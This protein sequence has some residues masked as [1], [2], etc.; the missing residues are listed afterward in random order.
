MRRIELADF[1]R[2]RDEYDQIVSACADLD[3]FCSSAAWVLPAH[4]S[5]MPKR[6]PLIFEASGRWITLARGSDPRGFSYLEP[7]EASWGL[8]SPLVAADA[9]DLSWV[10]ANE[11]WDL[12]LLAGLIDGSVVQART[13]TTLL[14]HYELR[15]G[16][17]TARYVADL[18][19]GLDAFLAN[20]SRGFR[21]S[22]LRSRKRATGAGIEFECADGLDAESAF[23]RILS[24]DDRSWKGLSGVGI[25]GTMRAFYRRMLDRLVERDS[26]RLHF[27][28]REDE[29]VAYIFGGVFAGTYRGL[30][31]GFDERFRELGLGNVCQ[32]V[33]IEALCEEGIETYDI[34]TTSGHYKQKWCD[35]I[36]TSTMF[37]V[38]RRQPR[39]L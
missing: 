24:V 17:A 25:T 20:R 19:G 29:D 5:L 26:L 31:F 7:L 9:D 3:R 23:Q 36:V 21:R 18:D 37:F 2:R 16:D 11:E 32:L 14:R 6:E 35:R 13:L 39:T 34:G 28:R 38:T 8:A 10:C 4:E 22:V 15:Q 33:Q 30:Q 12:V 1:R 27:A